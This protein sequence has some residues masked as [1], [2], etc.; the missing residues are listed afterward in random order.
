[1]PHT[2]ELSQP[3]S[4]QLLRTGAIGRVALATPDGPHLIPVRYAVFERTIVIRTSAYSV[5]GTYGPGAMLAFEV[6]HLD[7]DRG[8]GWSVVL[9]GRAW[10]ETDAAEVA[11][12]RSHIDARP[13]SPGN[14]NLY[15]RLPWHH[16][17]GRALVESRT[18]DPQSLAPHPMS[19]A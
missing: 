17:T 2:L 13:W 19:G 16:L 10:G 6:D 15:L 5:L 3:E 11:R 8:V 14:R 1:M 12:I 9:R 18:R 4:E 7:Q